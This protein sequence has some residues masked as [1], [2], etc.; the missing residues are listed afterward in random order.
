MRR[1][2]PSGDG[3]P[4]IGVMIPAAVAWLHQYLAQARSTLPDRR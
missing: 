3:E 1:P 2:G 4:D